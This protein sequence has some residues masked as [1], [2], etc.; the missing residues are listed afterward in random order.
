MLARDA[1]KTSN[2]FATLSKSTTSS[3]PAAMSVKPHGGSVSGSSTAS[4]NT[5]PTSNGDKKK[6]KKKSG[7]ASTNAVSSTTTS[8]NNDTLEDPDGEEIAKKKTTTFT[9]RNAE[10]GNQETTTDP[11]QLPLAKRLEVAAAH[12]DIHAAL[13]GLLGWSRLY[14][15]TD[16]ILEFF[17]SNALEMLLENILQAN[18][19]TDA[20]YDN[21]NALLANCLSIERNGKASSSNREIANAVVSTVRVIVDKLKGSS[22]SNQDIVAVTKVAQYLSKLV[23][24]YRLSLN[25]VELGSTLSEEILRIDTKLA[26]AASKDG[27]VQGQT[28][29]DTFQRRDIRCDALS[30]YE[31]RLTKVNQLVKDNISS[32][33]QH[34]QAT[35]AQDK[36]Q[37]ALSSGF[38][39]FA[40]DDENK[41]DP[42][43]LASIKQQ[44]Q[45]L[46]ERKTVEIAPLDAKRHDIQKN[47]Q[48]L[49]KKRE[50]LEAQLRAV[51]SEIQDTLDAHVVVDE[52]I[53]A[54]EDRFE[55]EMSRFDDEHQHIIQ[56]FQQKERRDQID[57]AFSQLQETIT[58]ISLE[59][60][61]VQPLKEKR[62][63]CLRQHLEGIL[64]Y[65]ASELPCVKFMMGRVEQ[66][67][68]QL[69]KFVNEAEGYKV[70]GVSAVAKELVEK[71]ESLQGHLDED[72]KCLEALQT[73]DLQL[74][75]TIKRL[76]HNS[77]H[78][79]ALAALD[80]ALKKEVQ[81]HVD[82]ISKIYEPVLR[83]S[84]NGSSSPAKSSTDAPVGSQKK[85]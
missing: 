52:Q 30:L 5:T 71:A 54:V 33:T 13:V 84:S 12:A 18:P 60:S 1:V 53:T 42:E 65:F 79:D 66:A 43:A 10:N 19:V 82:Y 38:L 25:G 21:L 63:V 47:L 41:L 17:Q 45:S 4:N 76:F 40:A 24:H 34:L 80:P 74:L 59:H 73:K 64:R 16:T 55:A 61:E 20:I 68:A 57:A 83:A 15:N 36:S 9:V 85:K 28:I 6:K 72:K 26:N 46:N 44:L 32:S 70:L 22:R 39:A 7:S 31:A 78:A 29:R 56:Q 50:E 8:E 27:A 35:N 11:S 3:R 49:K 77:E 2:L 23:L 37:D 75:D 14:V 81:R 51:N 62:V 67:E 48:V 69:Q 58:K